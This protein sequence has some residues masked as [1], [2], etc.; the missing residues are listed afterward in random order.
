M[1][2]S[3]VLNSTTSFFCSSNST[4]LSLLPLSTLIWPYSAVSKA[5]LGD[6]LFLASI[7]TRS[8][9]L[10]ATLHRCSPSLCQLPLKC[11][12]GKVVGK[13]VGVVKQIVN[14]S[15]DVFIAGLHWKCIT[16]C[17]FHVHCMGNV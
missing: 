12:L 4:W 8:P 11:V 1:W 7:P 3:Q 13:S 6:K 9:L 17:L 15:L 2:E 5:Y 16:L 14:V 10:V